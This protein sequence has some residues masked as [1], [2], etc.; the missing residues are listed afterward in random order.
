[1]LTPQRSDETAKGQKGVLSTALVASAPSRDVAAALSRGAAGRQTTPLTRTALDQSHSKDGSPSSADQMSA[2]LQLRARD[3]MAAIGMSPGGRAS[4]LPGSKSDEPEASAGPPEVDASRARS[5]LGAGTPLPA[6]TAQKFSKAYGHDLSDVRIHKSHPMPDQVGAR[7]FTV[8]KDVAFAP[9]QY[10]PGTTEGDRLIGHE[11]AHVVQQAGGE[12]AVQGA[13]LSNDGYEKEA[14]H[15]ADL[16]LSGGVA[17]RLT[18]VGRSLQ[19]APPT[20]LQKDDKLSILFEFRGEIVGV[21]VTLSQDM[22]DQFDANPT[23]KQALGND[24]TA[25]LSP[26]GKPLP[27]TGAYVKSAAVTRLI[28]DDLPTWVAGG[29]LPAL[30]GALTARA[31]ALRKQKVRADLEAHLGVAG[32]IDWNVQVPVLRNKF[33]ELSLANQASDSARELALLFLDIL[34]NEVAGDAP[35]VGAASPSHLALGVYSYATSVYKPDPEVVK[36]FSEKFLSRYLDAIAAIQFVPKGFDLTRYE[37]LQSSFADDRRNSILDRF[38]EKEGPDLAAKYVL[39]EWTRSGQSPESFLK[40]MHLESMRSGIIDFIAAEGVKKALAD[41]DLAEALRDT[42]ADKTRYSILKT[43]TDHGRRQEAYNKGLPP[44]S[45]AGF[46]EPGSAEEQIFADPW[47]YYDATT[48]MAG[49]VHSLLSSVRDGARVEQAVIEQ[50]AALIEQKKAPKTFG[51]GVVLALIASAVGALRREVQAHLAKSKERVAARVEVTYAKIVKILEQ[52][53]KAADAFI[54]QKWIPELKRIALVRIKAN[55][56]ELKKWLDNFEPETAAVVGRYIITAVF[57]EEAA[58]KLESGETESVSFDGATATKADLPKIRTAMKLARAKAASLS[59]KEGKSEK[60]ADLQKAVSAFEDVKAGIESGKYKPVDFGPSVGQE[61]K[62]N[63]GIGGFEEGTRVGQVLLRKVVADENPFQAWAITRWRFTEKVYEQSNQLAFMGAMALL[64]IASFLAPGAAGLVLMAVDMGIGTFVAARGV[65]KASAAVDLA[66][67]DTDQSVGGVSVEEAK[68]AL[69]HAWIG[70]VIS[71]ALGGLFSALGGRMIYKGIQARRLPFFTK[72]AETD[73]ALAGKILSKVED[74]KMADTLIG[75]FGDANKLYEALA[76]VKDGKSLVTLVDKIKDVERTRAL[77]MAAGH[78]SRLTPLLARFKNLP[79][80]EVMLGKAT[81]S[82]LIRLY[83]VARSE[84][85]VANL[86]AHMSPSQAIH[87]L[88]NGVRAEEAVAL[89]KLGSETLG[90]ASRIVK[91]GDSVS[92][93]AVR[94]L[95][96]LRAEKAFSREMAGDVLRRTSEFMMRHEGRVSGDFVSRFRRIAEAEKEVALGQRN[97][98]EAEANLAAAKAAGRKTGGIEKQVE[99]IRKNLAG[100]QDE[101]SRARV[102]VQ[103][104]EDI[105]AGKSPLGSG[106]S[107]HGIMENPTVKA[108]EFRVKGPDGSSVLVEVKAMGETHP[109]GKT[110]GNRTIKDN[111]EYAFGQIKTQSGISGE[112]GG[113]IRLD[114][115]TGGRGY[116]PDEAFVISEVQRRMGHLTKEPGAADLVRHIDVS[117]L[118]T[119][120]KSRMLR[121]EVSGGKTVLVP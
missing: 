120:G 105:L 47:V 21:G 60:R 116:V 22:K 92:V 17:P 103:I 78:E 12:S 42:A 112:K 113:Y 77:L 36:L 64:T 14:D 72:L 7:A 50:A 16:A 82:E 111:L 10:Q 5:L 99:G 97:L 24:V 55:H 69:T 62:K 58:K 73:A 52:R 96:R 6:P 104:A 119:A 35:V 19:K 109:A 2:H 93:A 70:L 81:P 94:E 28:Q 11:L 79:E 67:L 101:L 106:R 86:V 54:Q 43:I 20:V 71:A 57:L 91:A 85:A 49:V 65:A 95:L 3:P 1:M 114:L 45:R 75:K 100:R 76:Y 15:A 89:A 34:A 68:S 53:G 4:P 66:R 83:S 108:P 32:T 48:T 8:G 84:T 115:T 88:T 25:A 117:F 46:A 121:F 27:E 74:T 18:R 80:L 44:K 30:V 26:G 63:L 118:D 51:T 9:G 61:A 40:D 87:L 107:V 33:A 37:P 38:V 90:A 98:A 102:E 31:E 110:I 39:D 59:S 56:E 29:G 41:K 23:W 13:G